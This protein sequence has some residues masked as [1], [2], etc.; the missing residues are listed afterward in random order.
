M[1]SINSNKVFHLKTEVYKQMV[2]HCISEAPIEACGFISG[3]GQVGLTCWPVPN[4][5]ESPVR[6]AISEDVLKDTF[7][8]IEKKG[9][10]LTG[11]FH[12]HPTTRAYPS[13][14]DIKNHTYPTVVYII[15]SLL[16]KEPVVNCFYINKNRE[17]TTLILKLI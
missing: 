16:K 13:F 6:F 14:N 11:I 12:S 4:E 17:V 1:M 9:E 15:I 5:K 7:N 10:Q 2:E 8:K 3:K